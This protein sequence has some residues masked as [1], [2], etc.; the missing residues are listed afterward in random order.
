MAVWQEDVIIKDIYDVEHNPPWL[1]WWIKN[2]TWAQY[3]VQ[4]VRYHTFQA[5]T[6]HPAECRQSNIFAEQEKTVH[7]IQNPI[8]I[9][10]LCVVLL[11]GTFHCTGCSMQ[12]ALLIM[13]SERVSLH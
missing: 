12:V 13:H 6:P 11:L 2:D 4:C 8:T 5:R 9:L 3:V 10:N 1:M 7:A